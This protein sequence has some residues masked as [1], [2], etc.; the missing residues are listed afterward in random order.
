VARLL[1]SNAGRGVWRHS[2]PRVGAP[3]QLISTILRTASARPPAHG[4]LADLHAAGSGELLLSLACACRRRWP[5]ALEPGSRRV[6][7]LGSVRRRP[8]RAC[9]KPPKQI[10]TSGKFTLSM[11]LGLVTKSCPLLL[12]ERRGPRGWTRSPPAA[13]PVWSLAMPISNARGLT[14]KGARVPVDRHRIYC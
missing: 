4:R 6:V 8:A 12:F 11:T 7:A 14:P 3:G 9:A 1:R 10:R 2:P 13:L 5:A